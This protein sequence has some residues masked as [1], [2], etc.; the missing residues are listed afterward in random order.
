MTSVEVSSMGDRS[1]RLLKRRGIA[2]PMDWQPSDLK[3]KR[4]KSEEPDDVAD[5]ADDSGAT[6][7]ATSKLKKEVDVAVPVTPSSKREVEIKESLDTSNPKSLEPNDL[8]FK[9]IWN[10]PFSPK[11]EDL[12]DLMNL[13]SIFHR[14]L[15]KMPQEYILRLVMD[16]RHRSLI[17]KRVDEK[18]MFRLVGGICIRPFHSQK[19]AEIVF[20]AVS[21]GEQ[22][23]GHGTRLMNHLKEYVKTEGIEYFLTYADNYAI[24]YFKKQG[25]S[26]QIT[27]AQERWKDYIKDYDGG[28]LMEC[29]ISKF[30]S[31]LDVPGMLRDQRRAVQ[32]KIRAVSQADRTYPGI[33]DLVGA[34]DDK[35]KRLPIEDIPGVLEAGY[36][37]Y[38]APVR[39]SFRHG[40]GG[41]AAGSEQKHAEMVAKF[42]QI[43]K[44]IKSAKESWPFLRPVDAKKVPDYYDTIAEPMDLKTM[45]TKLAQDE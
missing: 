20:C 16:P 19:F 15:P 7:P 14:Q 36:V 45:S 40:T 8:L 38:V 2:T 37:G 5:P 42:G 23:R 33:P 4:A 43:I 21:A 18:G 9:M 12:R 29:R 41:R 25:F 6:P 24:G 1:D 32:D 13:K 27:L 31:Y 11:S 28:T 26:K 22:I 10:N 3:R 44:Q 35:E 17:C 34:W 30:V 39:K